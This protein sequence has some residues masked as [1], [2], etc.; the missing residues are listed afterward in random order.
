MSNYRAPVPGPLES[1]PPPLLP[2]AP[3]PSPVAPEPQAPTEAP[4]EKQLAGRALRGGAVLM[5]AK[6]AMQAVTWAVTLLVARLLDKTDYGIM[7]WAVVGLG[8]M[9]LLAEAGLGRAL[10]QKEGL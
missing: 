4:G 3:A 5:A 7:T 9:E 8:L 2:L 10:V 6:F 1:G